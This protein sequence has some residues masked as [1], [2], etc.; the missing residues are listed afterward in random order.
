MFV[1]EV[2]DSDVDEII[3]F[4]RSEDRTVFSFLTPRLSFRALIRT[5]RHR[6]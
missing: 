1:Q 4:L 2:F 6:R 3:D 5:S